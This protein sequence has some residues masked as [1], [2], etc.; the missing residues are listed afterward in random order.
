M[1]YYGDSYGGGGHYNEVYTIKKLASRFGKDLKMH[2]QIY[3]NNRRYYYF[4]LSQENW[5]TK[6]PNRKGT[7]M[8]RLIWLTPFHK[9]E[10]SQSG[11]VEFSIVWSSLYADRKKIKKIRRQHSKKV[12]G[13]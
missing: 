9:S 11:R 1:G 8:K 12:K 6:I 2:L 5:D 3:S 13:V 4:S 7:G 10:Q